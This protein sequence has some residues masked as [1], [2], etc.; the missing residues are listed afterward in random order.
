MTGTSDPV[1]SN[2][3][4]KIHQLHIDHL[5]ADV[6]LCRL[7]FVGSSVIDLKFPALRHVDYVTARDGLNAG[8]ISIRGWDYDRIRLR[9]VDRQAAPC[10]VACIY[11]DYLGTSMP[12]D[13]ELSVGC[14]PD[15]VVDSIG[16]DDPGLHHRHTREVDDCE[17][18]AR[19]RLSGLAGTRLIELGPVRVEWNPRQVHCRAIH[20]RNTPRTH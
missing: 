6:D 16:D 9:I 10:F 7:E 4:L 8:G 15:A 13:K 3:L 5:A 18:A 14:E 1:N 19:C 20:Q 2:L 11:G 12:A 17:Q